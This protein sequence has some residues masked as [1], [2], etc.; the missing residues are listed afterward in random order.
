MAV[1]SIRPL[2]ALGCA[3]AIASCGPRWRAQAFPTHPELYRASLEQL[4]LGNPRNAIAGF[5]RLTLE[6]GLRDSLLPLSHYYLGV[7]RMQA[8]DWLLAADAF[9][10][11][12]SSFPQD[13]LADDALLQSGRAY[14]ELWDDPELTPEYGQS[15]IAV[16]QTI[17]ESYPQSP[18]I[19]EAQAEITRIR[20]MLA[21]KDY[22][23]GEHYIRRFGAYHSGLIYLT[24][25]IELYPETQAARDAHIKAAE[26]Y[27][28]IR[29]TE[30]L[31][32]ICTQALTRYPDDAGV[33]DVCRGTVTASPPATSSASPPPARA[34]P[35]QPPPR[36]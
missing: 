7:A 28:K 33:R 23:V 26:A 2:T 18:L 4:R 16:L 9:T 20:E 22:R 30:D 8:K 17:A 12:V 14:A 11:M 21:R 29:Y 10:R 25:V 5:E 27:Q 32:E 35:P 19:P 3:L 34:P 36:R 24:D 31:R 6:L 13:T 1:T 15:A